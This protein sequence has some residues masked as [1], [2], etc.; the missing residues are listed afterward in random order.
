[1]NKEELNMLTDTESTTC[2]SAIMLAQDIER[3]V[4][5]A[6]MRL[7]EI[8]ISGFAVWRSRNGRLSVLFPRYP[9]GKMWVDV[10]EVPPELRA[11]IEADII[12]A[13]KAEKAAAAAREHQ[14]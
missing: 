11:Q 14:E 7:G 10:I 3:R 9:L 6:T 13:Y 2:V 8:A 1:V 5:F 4:A 12:S